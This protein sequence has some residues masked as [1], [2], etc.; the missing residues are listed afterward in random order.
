MRY[1]RLVP[2]VVLSLAPLGCAVARMQVPAELS[3]VEVW[4]VTGVNPR[5]WNR[6][7]SFGPWR[8]A[9]VRE[10]GTFGR[11]FEGTGVRA[12]SSHR[13]Y[14]FALPG[15]NGDDSEVACL[16]RDFTIERGSFAADLTEIGGPKLACTIRSAGSDSPATLVLGRRGTG[17][18]GALMTTTDAYS[19][20]SVHRIEGSSFT[21]PDPVG[22]TIEWKG[23]VIAAV[24]V[25]D[26]GYVRIA[27]PHDDTPLLA[28]TAA[29]LLL[30]DPEIGPE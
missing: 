19:I 23:S 24:E 17:Y 6:P 16:T 30:F 14:R 2:L 4:P 7:V 1:L 3:A 5:V 26:R 10:P 27:S 21:T 22:Y 29:A 12:T 25:L 13:P 9:A 11:G 15:P 28:A 8:T 18:R 20:R